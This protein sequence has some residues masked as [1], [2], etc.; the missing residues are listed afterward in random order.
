MKKKIVAFLP[1]KG[2]SQRILNKNMKLLD[3][4]PLFLH[5]LEK[6]CECEFI[7]E[8]YLDSESDEILNW[9]SYLR[10][11][12]LK[13][14][15]ALATNQTDGHQMFYNEVRQVKADIYIQILGTSPFIEKETIKRGIDA[16]ADSGYDSAVLVR[17]DKQ[18]TWNGDGPEYDRNHVPNSVDLPDTVTET[19]GL[20]IV[21]SETAHRM[22][23]RYGKKVFCL[24]AKPIEAVDVNFPDDFDFAEIIMKGV[25]S[26]ET[27]LF[28]MLSKQLSSSIFADILTDL[29]WDTIIPGMKL[30]ISDV[31]VMGRANT[32]S[33]R[34][35]G[36]GEDFNGIY[37]ALKTYE[38]VRDGEVIVVENQCPEYAYFGELNANLAIRSGAIA[39]I[40]DGVT[41]DS[42][43][44]RGLGY[45]VF[46]K[47][48]S[49]RDVRGRGT[50]KSHNQPVCIGSV[51]IKPGDIIMG[52]NDGVAVIPKEIETLVIN[53]A[54]DSVST[55]KSVLSRIINHED[56]YSIYKLEGAF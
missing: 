23:Q 20:Y 8:V 32:L 38:S 16:I 30:N 33:L 9:A 25:H 48:F 24:E 17:R 7:D 3:G 21:K 47:G 39:T 36:D 51:K 45:P 2:S 52:D 22:K 41:R 43:A 40:V 46:A 18:Y 54:I 4:K 44:V 14:D 1:A 53:R 35:L 55:E 11:I 31:R 50:L 29:G 49:C 26:R 6:L 19:M 28:R 56:A 5:T 34:R 27:L 13:R 12:P 15:P 10:Y 37:D 42:Q